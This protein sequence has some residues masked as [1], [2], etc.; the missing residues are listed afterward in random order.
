[1]AIR[2]E[3]LFPRAADS[4]VWLHLVLA[5]PKRR[6][7]SMRTECLDHL[8]IF[9]EGHLRRELVLGGLHHVYSRASMT[10][11]APLG[12]TPTTKIRP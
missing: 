8:F 7:K 5:F 1:M 10:D 12:R 11:F 6:A 4:I 3:R 9:T 2:F